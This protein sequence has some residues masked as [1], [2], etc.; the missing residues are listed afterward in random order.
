MGSVK[1]LAVRGTLWTIVGYG[2]SQIL[3]F[4]SNLLLTRLLYP[5]LFGLMGIVNIFIVG[6]ALFSDIGIGYNII[7]NKRGDEPDFYN[8]AWT[9]QV[10]RGFGLWAACLVIALP[11]SELY[12]QPS[13]AWLIPVVGFTT[14]FSG[15]SS[16]ALF[17]LERHINLRKQVIIEMGSQVIGLLSM[18]IWALL[19]PTVLSLAV[20]GLVSGVTK[21]IWSHHILPDIKNRFLWDKD[22]V[23]EILSVGRWVFVSTATM[24]L[25]EQSDRLMLGAMFPLGLFGIYQITLTLSDVPRQILQTLSGRVMFPVI[26]KMIDQPRDLV[27]EKV[28]SGRRLLLMASALMLSFLVGFGDILIKFLYDERYSS[29]AWMLPILAMGLWPRMLANTSEPFLLSIG[30]FQY[31]AYGNLLR[32]LSTVIGILIGFHFFQVPGAIFAVALNDL[33]YYLAI[34]YGLTNEGFNSI[35]QDVFFTALLLAIV[36][37][38]FVIRFYSGLGSPIQV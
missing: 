33:F 19:S 2:G 10:I 24:F 23:K 7:Q 15:F 32:L 35:P 25:A 27:I 20:G 13:L 18:F 28:L 31:S 17:S 38:M 1:K 9:I 37:I 21:M 3:R 4:G 11:I 29:E 22:S 34:V 5:E 12:N 14:I 30:K 8:T 6:L 16:T 26:S 36:A